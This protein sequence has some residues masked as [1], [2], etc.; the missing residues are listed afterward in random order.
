MNSEMNDFVG[1]ILR[2]KFY[3]YGYNLLS[4]TRRYTPICAVG[5]LL[6]ATGA[7]TL[8]LLN[9]ILQGWAIIFAAHFEKAA[10]S[11]GPCL[12]MRVEASLGL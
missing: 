10:F 4:R 2:N 12:L 3:A 7:E 11:G 5:M 1:N 6:D 9:C 8:M